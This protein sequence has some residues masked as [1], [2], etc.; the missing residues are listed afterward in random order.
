LR[1]PWKKNFQRG[2]NKKLA[3][4]RRGAIPESF[5]WV[6]QLLGW[7]K[8]FTRGIHRAK[9]S[10]RRSE[11]NFRRKTENRKELMLFQNKNAAYKRIRFFHLSLRPR[12]NKEGSDSRR[13]ETDG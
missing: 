5:L 7:E 13:F 8:N 9:T 1:G 6:A 4:I 3:L 11:H 10:Q 2:K 12:L